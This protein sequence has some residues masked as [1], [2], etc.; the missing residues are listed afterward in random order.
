MLF[1]PIRKNTVNTITQQCNLKR[2][3][4]AQQYETTTKETIQFLTK[5]LV[6]KI[7]KLIKTLNRK[8]EKNM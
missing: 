2:L 1:T 6:N 3:S 7:N 5:C 8:I 4:N